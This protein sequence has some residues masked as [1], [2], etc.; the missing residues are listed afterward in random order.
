MYNNEQTRYKAIIIILYHSLGNN[1][2]EVERQFEIPRTT[3]R[4][5]YNSGIEIL[6]QHV[7]NNLKSIENGHRKL[8]STLS[9]IVND[10][11]DSI[12]SDE[13]QTVSM[14]SELFKTKYFQPAKL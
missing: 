13:Q 3:V 10:W 2:S 7:T 1:Y 6:K 8:S 5:L 11:C 14:V 4:N 12:G 9:T